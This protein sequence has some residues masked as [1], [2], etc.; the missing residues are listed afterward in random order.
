[1]YDWSSLGIALT[2]AKLVKEDIGIAKAIIVKIY[3]P[4]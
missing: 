3:P 1:M 4:V 2:N